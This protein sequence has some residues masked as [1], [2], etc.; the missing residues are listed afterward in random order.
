MRINTLI[1]VSLLVL[2][3][4]G[5][6]GTLHAQT[7]NFSVTSIAFG[8]VDTLISTNQDASGSVSV[9]CSGLILSRV[10]GTISVG[11]GSG[12]ASGSLRDLQGPGA[13]LSFQL[14]KD[15]ARSQVLGNGTAPI[16]G[17]ALAFASGS[18]LLNYSFN[19]PFYGR[20][21]GGQ[22]SAPPGSY[23]TTFVGSDLSI[24]YR[25]CTAIICGGYTTTTL[26]ASATATVPENCL[27][28]ASD[29]DFGSNGSLVQAIVANGNI[30]VRCTFSTG[31]QVGLD[32]GQN[33]P[34]AGIRAMKNAS[35]ELITY[36]LF[37]DSAHSI[38]WGN[39]PGSNTLGGSGTGVT[40]T[41]P[42]Y[43]RVPAQVTPP[44]SSYSD[45]IVVTVT[46]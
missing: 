9:S 7:C 42:V 29:I 39:V 13:Q 30:F 5:F 6:S 19:V 11:T 34:S 4:S 32:S 16:N 25:T 10:E 3:C 43:G 27:V 28:S 36:E 41:L 14:Y 22:T 21:F 38:V 26:S 17:T 33:S 12:G 15:A 37:Q 2:F 1:F 23:L 40:L 24:R 8:D 20:V 44:A 18:L 46:Y 45:I 31:F 35:G